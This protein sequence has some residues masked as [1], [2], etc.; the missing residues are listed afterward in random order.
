MSDFE[1]W[2][3]RTLGELGHFPE[4]P[5]H[6]TGVPIN[7]CDCDARHAFEAGEAERDALM[8]HNV[9]NWVLA[10]KAIK[11]F[12]GEYIGQPAGELWEWAI[13]Q[14]TTPEGVQDG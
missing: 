7:E 9:P 4:C 3:A 8:A 5:W 2:K 11:L 1:K 14:A 13:A 6:G 12:E 10:K